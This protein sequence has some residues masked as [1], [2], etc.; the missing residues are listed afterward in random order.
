MRLPRRFPTQNPGW[1]SGNYGAC[2]NILR[3]DTSST[4]SSSFTDCQPAKDGGARAQRSPAFDGCRYTSPVG[5]SLEGSSRGGSWKAIVYERDAMA[6][7]DLILESHPF[8]EE[9]MTG[10][11]AAIANAHSFLDL[12]ERANLHIIT[13][14][15]TVEIGEGVDLD[16]LPK[17]NI[18]RD[19]P[20]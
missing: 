8:A 13:D 15:T 7:K 19:A 18:R 16:A 14:F 12:D 5:L 10:N 11:F 4:N 1:V 20:V 2:G 6:N 9:R 3:Y 17:L